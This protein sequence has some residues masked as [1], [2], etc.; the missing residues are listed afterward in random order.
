VDWATDENY[1][2]DLPD[3]SDRFYITDIVFIYPDAA[4]AE[5]ERAAIVLTIPRPRL[6]DRC[7]IGNLAS[8][9]LGSGWSRPDQ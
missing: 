4:S 5:E 6:Q 3:G 8:W 7:G 1:R 2:W 9:R